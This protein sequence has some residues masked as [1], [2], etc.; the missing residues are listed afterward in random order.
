MDSTA[1]ALCKDNNIPVL[2]FDLARPDNIFDACMG[3][4]VGTL[5]SAE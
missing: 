1:A 5:V 2:V 3:E 4:N